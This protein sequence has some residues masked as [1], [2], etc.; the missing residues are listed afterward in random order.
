VFNVAL[1]RL[2]SSPGVVYSESD[3]SLFSYIGWKGGGFLP[4]GIRVRNVRSGTKATRLHLI[5]PLLASL[6]DLPPFARNPSAPHDA[7]AKQL[8]R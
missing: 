8:I 2:I 1:R 5:M 4:T 6:P 7:A 3:V